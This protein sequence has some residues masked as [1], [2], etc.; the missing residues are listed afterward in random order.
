MVANAILRKIVGANFFAAIAGFDLVA[1]FSGDRLVLLGLF[2]FV[3]T[4]AQHAH[5]FGAILDLGFFILLRNN[6]A[7]GNVGDAHGGIGGV[8]GLSTG[9]GGAERVDP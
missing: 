7:A 2:L 8:H 5:G 3:K 4:G 6:Q 1:A 9:P